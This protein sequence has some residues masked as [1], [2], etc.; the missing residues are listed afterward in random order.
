MGYRIKEKRTEI[1]M[2]QEELSEKSGVSRSIISGLENGTIRN[3]KI[4]TLLALAKAMN[5]S[6]HEI[7]FQDE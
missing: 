3:T 2:S 6:I 1:G 7:F 4:G 5:T